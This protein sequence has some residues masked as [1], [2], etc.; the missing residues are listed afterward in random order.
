MS[1]NLTSCVAIICLS[2]TLSESLLAQHSDQWQASVAS[3]AMLWAHIPSGPSELVGNELPT[4]LALS[5]WVTMRHPTPIGSGALKMLADPTIG[6][7]ITR[8]VDSGR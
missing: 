7:R 5:R 1:C 3:R 8:K 4:R 2:L 6:D